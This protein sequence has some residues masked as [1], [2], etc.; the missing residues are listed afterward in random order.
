MKLQ[1]YVSNPDF[2]PE[3]VCLDS[4]SE[5]IIVLLHSLVLLYVSVYCYLLKFLTAIRW[6]RYLRPAGRCACGS[7][8]LIFTPK[9]SKTS[10]PREKNWPKH[11]SATKI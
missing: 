9:S 11:R 8:L 2:I 5:I 10:G 6:R 1:K 3:K 4:T 7:E